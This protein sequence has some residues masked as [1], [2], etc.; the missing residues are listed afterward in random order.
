MKEFLSTNFDLYLMKVV[1]EFISA[2]RIGLKLVK[3]YF[4]YRK[5]SQNAT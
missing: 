2:L 5:L 3:K 1:N 4:G